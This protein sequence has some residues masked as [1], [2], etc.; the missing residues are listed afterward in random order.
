MPY[1]P[2]MTNPRTGT[3]LFRG[4]TT[5]DGIGMAEQNG[6]IA[7]PEHQAFRSQSLLFIAGIRIRIR[8][9]RAFAERCRRP[10][11]TQTSVG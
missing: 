8:V 9:R 11:F 10:C 7:L 1:I 6:G 3:V 4:S 2:Y 5:T